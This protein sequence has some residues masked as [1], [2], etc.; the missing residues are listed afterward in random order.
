MKWDNGGFFWRVSC[1]FL[2]NCLYWWGSQ[3][4][5]SRA[6]AFSFSSSIKKRAKLKQVFSFLEK[7]NSTFILDSDVQVCY[8][9]ILRD[10]EA[11]DD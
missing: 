1:L 3:L 11:V 7:K 8:L 5:G 4:A 9:G 2:E 6:L 10:T